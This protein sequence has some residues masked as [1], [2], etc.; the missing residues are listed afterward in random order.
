MRRPLRR[1]PLTLAIVAVLAACGGPGADPSASADPSEASSPSAAASAPGASASSEPSAAP[2]AP[3]SASASAPPS[4]P[5]SADL[6][7]DGL[8]IVLVTDLIV[9]SAP[10]VDPATSTILPDRLTTD[11]RLVVLDG[12]T[13]A[14]GYAWYLVAP[15]GRADGTAGPFGWVAAASREG[16]A[17]VAGV[18]AS[19]PATVDLASVLDLHA[20][21]RIVCFGNDSLT[22]DGPVVSCGIADG[23]WQPEPS[24]LSG[25]A[26]CGLSLD[27][28]SQQVLMLRIPP[29]G[30]SVPGPSGPLRVTGHFDDP[31]A[32]TCT[33]TTSDPVS[34]P[35]PA[36]ELIVLMCRTEFVVDSV[37]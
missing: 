20:Y 27:A 10:G 17:W 13:D 11:D 3:A 33:I 4:A 30:P 36:R 5:A 15:L 18:A 7:V 26:G 21:E 9:R 1:S 12:P 22:L 37:P 16:E 8:A 35:V 2:S 31:A 19:C 29:G 25:M 34:A 6:A 24:W 28:S 23:P 14:D 32:A